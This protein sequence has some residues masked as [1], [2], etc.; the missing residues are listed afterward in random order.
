VIPGRRRLVGAALL[1]AGAAVGAGTLARA[2]VRHGAADVER[3][4]ICLRNLHTAE[5]LE[6]EYFRGGYVP[7]ALARIDVLLRDFRTGDVYPIDPGLIDQLRSVALA[8][9]RPPVFHVISGYRS[10]RTN[11]WLRERGGGVAL[12]S[13]HMDGRAMDVRLVGIDCATLSGAALGLA[14]GGVGYYRSSDFVH[15]DTGALRS[16][17]G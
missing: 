5:E 16:W 2:A 14:R 6:V 1:A 10:P 3:R 15:L 11:E 7:G 13:L 17:R 8:L 12:H 9:E 4:S